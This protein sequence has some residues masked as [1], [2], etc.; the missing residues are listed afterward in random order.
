MKHRLVAY[1]MMFIHCMLPDF[2]KVFDKS[3]FKKSV[4]L[5]YYKM[6]NCKNIINNFLIPTAVL[7]FFSFR[8]LR[9]RTE[10]KAACFACLESHR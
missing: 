6:K 5:F 9:F 4:N 1:S 3:L 10:F 2:K 7:E 8:S